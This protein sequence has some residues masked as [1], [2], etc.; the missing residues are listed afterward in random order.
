MAMKC[1]LLFVLS[2]EE[3]EQQVFERSGQGKYFDPIKEK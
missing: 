2:G 1:T 3:H